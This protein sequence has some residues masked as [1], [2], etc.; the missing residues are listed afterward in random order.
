MD[1]GNA[2]PADIWYR[3][4][5]NFYTTNLQAALGSAASLACLGEVRF[6]SPDSSVTHSLNFP[7]QVDAILIPETYPPVAVLNT[8]PSV[9][10]LQLKTEKDQP[11]GYPG[12]NASG[13]VSCS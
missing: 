1:D 4:Q 11:F 6:A 12:L 2:P 10:T 9:G 13:Y 3:G 8:Y 5:P 7:I